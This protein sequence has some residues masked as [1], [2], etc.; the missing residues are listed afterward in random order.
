MDSIEEKVAELLI[1]I[2]KISRML[3]QNKQREAYDTFNENI[4][5]LEQVMLT[6]IEAIPTLREIGIDIPEEVIITQLKNMTEGY[7]LK[8]NILL[9]DTLEYEIMDSLCVYKEILEQI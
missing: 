1:E 7:Q 8:D 2:P 4:Q 5:K 9:A 6:F 3:Y